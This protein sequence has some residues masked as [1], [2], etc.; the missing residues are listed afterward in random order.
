MSNLVDN[1]LPIIRKYKFSVKNS[2]IYLI[3]DF[4][5]FQ[6]GCMLRFNFIQNKVMLFELNIN[7]KINMKRGESEIKLTEFCEFC[8]FNI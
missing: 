5:D 7:M 4:S 2:K 8:S 1:Y 6:K 3:K